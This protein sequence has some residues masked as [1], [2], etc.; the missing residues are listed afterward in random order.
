MEY[1]IKQYSLQQ[2]A[3]E[4]EYIEE[5]FLDFFTMLPQV[6]KMASRVIVSRW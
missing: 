4:I 1:L 2:G 6:G 3:P 5:F